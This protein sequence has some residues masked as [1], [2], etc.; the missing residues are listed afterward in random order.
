[1]RKSEAKVDTKNKFCVKTKKILR[2]CVKMKKKVAWLRENEKKVAWLR[3][4]EKKSCVIAWLD[5][6]PGGASS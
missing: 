2:D 6:P 3:E 5:T 4:N 1:M